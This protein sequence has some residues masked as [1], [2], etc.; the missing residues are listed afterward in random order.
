MQKE[1]EE[2]DFRTNRG[3]GPS[4]QPSRETTLWP[5]P[6]VSPGSFR[7]FRGVVGQ[8]SIKTGSQTARPSTHALSSRAPPGSVGDHENHAQLLRLG[9]PTIWVVGGSFLLS[10]SEQAAS[11]HGGLV[12]TRRSLSSIGIRKVCQKRSRQG[13]SAFAASTIPSPCVTNLDPPS[14]LVS[15]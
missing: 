12:N 1:V 15:S 7:A 11:R 5:H 8:I 9:A 10:R 4:V 2:A 3:L 14:T 13:C 6:Q